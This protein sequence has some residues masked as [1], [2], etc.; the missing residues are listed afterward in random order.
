MFKTKCEISL[1][2]GN[3]VRLDTTLIWMHRKSADFQHNKINYF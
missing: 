3:I 1:Q 2:I